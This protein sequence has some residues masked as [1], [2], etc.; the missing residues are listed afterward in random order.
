M[1]FTVQKQSRTGTR[2]AM[3]VSLCL[4]LGVLAAFLYHPPPAL[5]NPTSSLRGNG[6]GGLTKTALVAPGASILSAPR[7]E[8]PKEEDRRVALRRREKRQVAK[9]QP[10]QEAAVPNQSLRPGMPGYILGS[11]STGFVNDHDVKVALP[12]I[13]PDP[14]IARAKLPEWIRGDVVVE[15]TIS[16]QG[17]VTQTVVLSTVGFGLEDIIVQTLRQWRFVP[18]KVDGIAVASRQDVHYHFPS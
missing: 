8:E 13:A 4:H 12:V 18:A 16:E 2:T 3:V 7:K 9:P 6:G 15:V 10:Q 17:E 14:P 1:M 11:L 5:L